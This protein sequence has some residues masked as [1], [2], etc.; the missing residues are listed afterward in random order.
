MHRLHGSAQ[1]ISVVLPIA[2]IAAPAYGAA[3]TA[4]ALELAGEVL[5]EGLVLRQVV[6]D[7]DRLAAAAL[8]LE[9]QLGHHL[10]RHGD[11]SCELAGALAVAGGPAA[12]RAQTAGAS[13]VDGSGI[14]ATHNA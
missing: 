1:R 3:N 11:V 6:D 14:V 12:G 5:Q 8:L 13:G 2:P 10:R 4:R 9:A 7:R